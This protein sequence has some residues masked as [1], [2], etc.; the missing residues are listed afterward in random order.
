M[1]SR[2]VLPFADVGSG[3]KPPSGA[4]LFFFETGT[5]TPKDTFTDTE[6]LTPNSNP[7]ISDSN[8]VFS[9]I[10]I[11]GT[12]KVILQDKNSVQI[13][14][15]DPVSEYAKIQD[16]AFVKNVDLL[17]TAIND[18]T[19]QEGD[20]LNI[21]ER[22]AGKGNGAMWDVVLTSSVTPN[23]ADIVQSVGIPTL[24]LQLRKQQIMLASWFGA[25]GN[26]VGSPQDIEWRRVFEATKDPIV[27]KM[28][29]P[30]GD[31]YVDNSGGF[32]DFGGDCVF[33]HEGK[34]HFTNNDQLVLVGT[35]LNNITWGVKVFGLNESTT[36][37]L[38]GGYVRFV[39]CKNSVADGWAVSNHA[40][41]GLKLSKCTNWEIRNGNGNF[42]KSTAV[43]LEGCR[44][45][46]VHHNVLN[47][48]GRNSVDETYADMPAG[49]TSLVGRGVTL[50]AHT[51]GTPCRDC[52]VYRNEAKFNSEYGI[53]SFGESP[54]VGNIDCDIYKNECE[55]NGAP[56]GTYGGAIGLPAKGVD[57]LLNGS[58]VP[59]GDSLRLRALDNKI[60]RTFAFGFPISIAG[61]FVEANDNRIIISGAALHLIGAIQMFNATNPTVNGN[62]SFGAFRHIAQA[63]GVENVTIE[64]NIAIDCKEFLQ[65]WATGDFNFVNGNRAFHTT[66]SVAISGEN[67][68]DFLGNGNVDG[69]F[70]VGF[71]DGITTGGSTIGNLSR[72]ETKNIANIDFLNGAIN[73]S[74][75]Y[76][77]DNSF[78]VTSPQE[79]GNMV[80]ETFGTKRAGISYEQNI[81]TDGY[82]KRGHIAI[83]V[84]N[85]EAGT[86]AWRKRVEGTGHVPVVDWQ[87][88]TAP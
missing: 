32:N 39:N 7:V 79:K 44:N 74:A 24:S 71:Y 64:D 28:I 10:F 86:W 85:T 38:G 48:N 67:G 13:W 35:N 12:Y 52:D 19:L 20:A 88:L 34:L 65:N 18:A 59:G 49:S 78:V 51:D 37:F 22:D 6:A 70:L 41:D 46:D 47:S 58:T 53:R 60:K 83:N 33:E 73:N 45:V 57:I 76:Q 43:T 84:G 29:L 63:T 56:A 66:A 72:N 75:F 55:D 9:D 1:A 50:V 30:V 69:N 17:V 87:S 42:G 31:W 11:T 25:G 8:G 27:S 61:T 40:W 5:N 81:P 54:R 4:K 80:N 2:F 3:I 23:T 36:G 26:T 68:I 16:S 82:Y 77:Q 62:K 21:K 14:E 15:A